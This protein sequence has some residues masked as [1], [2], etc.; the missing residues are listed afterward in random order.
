MKLNQEQEEIYRSF[1]ERCESAYLSVR[2]KD[3]LS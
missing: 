2:G 3:D 1:L